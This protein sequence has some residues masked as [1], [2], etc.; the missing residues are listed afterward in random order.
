M[1]AKEQLEKAEKIIDILFI[2]SDCAD[3]MD[4][5]K[6]HI[7]SLKCREWVL[8]LKPEAGIALQIAALA[9]YIDRTNEKKRA[10][11]ENF[12]NYDEYK[13]KHAIESANIICEKLEIADFNKEL[14]E[15]VRYLIEHHEVSGD[16]ESDVLK[17][18]DSLTF[19]NF[20][21]YPYY[22]SMG[23]QKTKEKIKFMYKRLSE[24]AKKMIE[25]VNY[26]NPEIEAL[27]NEIIKE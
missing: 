25:D 17:N 19:F 4:K 3:T 14:I 23:H 11:K 2:N 18:A 5:K 12:D 10:K 7:H 13:R 21:I 26:G 6:D 22:E 15:R 9:H 16:E 24:K 20:D 1:K 27:V 8:K